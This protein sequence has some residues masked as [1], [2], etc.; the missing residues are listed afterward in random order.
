MG[1]KSNFFT[2]A[3]LILVV[4][5]IIK[6][7]STERNQSNLGTAQDKE[8]Q[9]HEFRLIPTAELE[10][11]IARERIDAEREA[12]IEAEFN[13]PELSGEDGTDSVYCPDHPKAPMC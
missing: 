8:V 6:L 4:A 12:K 5:I 11:D 7:W 3:F 9:L 13:K 1:V 10:R 2:L